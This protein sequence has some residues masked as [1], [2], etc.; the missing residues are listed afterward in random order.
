MHWADEIAH[1]LVEKHPD[2]EC[3]T[4]ASGISPSGPVHMG[5]LREVITTFFVAK[6][7]RD[8]GKKVRFIYS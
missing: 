4:C 1:R 5:N 3:F 6:G 8:L 7:L 2:L